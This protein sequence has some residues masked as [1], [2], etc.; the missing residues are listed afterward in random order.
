MIAKRYWL[1]GF[2]VGLLCG[3]SI[4]AAAAVAMIG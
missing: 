3:V 2:A 4:G 1:R